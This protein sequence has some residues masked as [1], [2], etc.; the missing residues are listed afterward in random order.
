MAQADVLRGPGAFSLFPAEQPPTPAPALSPSGQRHGLEEL[1]R[2]H[3]AIGCLP[4][5]SPG[6]ARLYSPQQNVGTFKKINT[7]FI[8]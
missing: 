4:P 3:E 8:F 7:S 5:S 1:Q 2:Q 6:P